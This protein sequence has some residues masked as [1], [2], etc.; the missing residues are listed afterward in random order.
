MSHHY[1][2]TKRDAIS[3]IRGR[4]LDEAVVAEIKCFA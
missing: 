3:Y 2:Y 4:D 1:K